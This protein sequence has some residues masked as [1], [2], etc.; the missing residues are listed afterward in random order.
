[1]NAANARRE[2]LDMV[3]SPKC[4]RSSKIARQR[5]CNPAAGRRGT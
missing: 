5:Q 3:V 4:E 1:M 2:I